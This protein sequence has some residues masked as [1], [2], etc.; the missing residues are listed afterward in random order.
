MPSR[1]Q[2]KNRKRSS[3]AEAHSPS[4]KK[5][6][7]VKS[8]DISS[9]STILTRKDSRPTRVYADG[10]YDLFHY[11]HSRSLE[12]A[13]KLFPNVYLLVGGKS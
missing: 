2:G 10:I 13:K 9:H 7:S 12:Q 5:R 1:R 8:E 3:K 6:L 11:G 4:K